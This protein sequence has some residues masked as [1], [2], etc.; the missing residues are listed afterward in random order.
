MKYLNPLIWTYFNEQNPCLFRMKQHIRNNVTGRVIGFSL[1]TILSFVLCVAC[2][3]AGETRHQTRDRRTAISSVR[4][5]CSIFVQIIMLTP[6][7]R[8]L[9]YFYVYF[10][11]GNGQICNEYLCGRSDF[12]LCCLFFLKAT[13][14]CTKIFAHSAVLFHFFFLLIYNILLKYAFYSLR[15]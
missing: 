7:G 13:C 11:S 3:S 4:C 15:Y 12:G 6:N 10:I 1:P 14:S 5:L 8:F 9:I 2:H